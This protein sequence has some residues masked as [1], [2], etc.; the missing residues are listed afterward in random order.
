[1]TLREHIEGK[2]NI[3]N[4]LVQ[5]NQHEQGSIVKG[6][7]LLSA[8]RDRKSWRALIIYILKIYVT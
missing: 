7:T 3:P 4:E 5:M 6:Q 2:S 8:T 1:M